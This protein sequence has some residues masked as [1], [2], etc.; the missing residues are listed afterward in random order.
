[1]E[2]ENRYLE[3]MEML[4]GGDVEE[5]IE[6]LRSLLSF[7]EITQ[8]EYDYVL[9]NYDEL[10]V[11]MWEKRLWRQNMKEYVF[12]ELGYFT[13]STVEKIK[14][15]MNGKTF[16]NFQVGCSVQAGANCILIVKTDYEDTENNIKNFFLNS[17]IEN[18]AR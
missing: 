18:M 8:S 9:D 10:F 4:D 5:D 7:G 16:M 12:E 14:S 15:A 13:P 6:Q 17:L 1:M 3:I 2:Y 11:S